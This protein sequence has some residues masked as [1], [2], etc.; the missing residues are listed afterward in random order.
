MSNLLIGGSSLMADAVINSVSTEVAALPSEN[1]LNEQPSRV[2]RT[3]SDTTQQIIVDLGA[4]TTVNVNFAAL[5]WTN[6]TTAAS[7]RCR[8][9]PTLVSIGGG[10]PTFDSGTITPITQAQ[11]DMGRQ[12]YVGFDTDGGAVTRY[13]KFEISDAA[14]P[15]GYIQAGRILL[16]NAWQP[17][18]NMQYG[19]AF[20]FVDKSRKTRSLGSRL[21]TLHIPAYLEADFT[22]GFQSEAE[23]M[24]SALP[25]DHD[26]NAKLDMVYVSDPAST[27]KHG[28]IIH[29]KMSKLSPIV[30]PR[31]GIYQK[32]YNV[33]EMI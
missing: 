32:K 22:L 8:F 15:D 17:A 31:Y 21:S 12:H 18:I 23:M 25:L 4:L 14:N 24:D 9:G 28:S 19:N 6:L 3:T 13:L 11:V 29:G 26:I 2:W 1:V 7:I 16:G 30:N 5:L 20:G 10:T 33:E 27:Y